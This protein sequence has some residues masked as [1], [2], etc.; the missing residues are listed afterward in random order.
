M[1]FC[2]KSL[3]HFANLNLL[4]FLKIY[5]LL[6]NQRPYKLYK[7]SSKYV[8]GWFQK[9]NIYTA[10]FPD[11][12]ELHSRSTWKANVCILRSSHLR[13][14]GKKGVLRNFT[15]FTGK[16]LCQSLFFNKVARPATLLK[17]RFWHRCFPVNI[18]KFLRKPFLPNTSGRLLL[19]IPVYLRKKNSSA[20]IWWGLN[21]FLRATCCHL[22]LVKYFK[23]F[24]FSWDFWKLNGF[25]ILPSIALKC[26]NFPEN[27]NFNV[28]I[29]AKI[30]IRNHFLSLCQFYSI[31]SPVYIL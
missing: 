18:V 30:L 5:S 2:Q 12:Q 19:Y 15:I 11:A 4:N 26:W 25:L 29:V 10:P 14:F 17:K 3:I 27:L 22:G 16:Q 20:F 1:Q 6:H 13:C 9:K 24:H 8:S 31:T 28:K 21:N 23:F 7:L